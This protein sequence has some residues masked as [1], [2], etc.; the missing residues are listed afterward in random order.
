VPSG[1]DRTRLAVAREEARKQISERMKK[2]GDS[3][4]L[5]KQIK[6]FGREAALR[7]TP[8]SRK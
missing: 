3:A 6:N 2:A 1:R 7:E 8:D 4:I 5:K